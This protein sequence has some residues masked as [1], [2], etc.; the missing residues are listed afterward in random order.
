MV[1]ALL[2]SWYLFSFF[3]KIIRVYENPTKSALSL[4]QNQAAV[5]KNM[6]DDDSHAAGVCAIEE[7]KHREKKETKETFKYRLAHRI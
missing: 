6:A 1:C 2:T 3:A 5:F 4:K 7:Q